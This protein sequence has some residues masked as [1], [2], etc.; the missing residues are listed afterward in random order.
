[1]RSELNRDSEKLRFPRLISDDL[2]FSE[3][4]RDP[5]FG[6]AWWLMPVLLLVVI[7]VGAISV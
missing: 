4:G 3:Y 2:E 7:W 1:M 6:P 5:R